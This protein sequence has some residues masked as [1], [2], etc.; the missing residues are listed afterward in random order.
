MEQLLDAILELIRLLL[1]HILDPRPV[2]AERRVGHGG[3]KRR[4]VDA[5]EFER[6]EQQMQR[7]RGDALLHVAVEFRAHRIDGIAGVNKTGERNQPP[8]Q[9]VERLVA[10]DRLDELSVRR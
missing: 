1:A 2:M 4:I 9:V 6:E 3:F 7:G 5:V 8:E 10:L